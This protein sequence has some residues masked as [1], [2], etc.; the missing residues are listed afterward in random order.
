MKSRVLIIHNE[1]AL[2]GGE[3][4]AVE[5]QRQLFEKNGHPVAYYSR[6]NTETSRYSGVERALF[7]PSTVFS[8]RT[9]RDIRKLVREFKPDVAHV[10]N[11]FPLISPSAYWALRHEGVPIIQTVHNF[12]LMCSNG[13]FFRAGAICELCKNG[14]H[15]NAVRFRCYRDSRLLSGLYATTLSIHRSVRTWRIIDRF[16]ALNSFTAGKLVDSGVARP[17]QVTVLGN[18]ATNAQSS[19]PGA[20]PREPAVVF[21][22]RLSVE[23][24]VDVLLE[25]ARSTPELTVRILGEGP[26]EPE[27]RRQAQGLPNV[28]FLGRIDGRERFEI[29]R[30]A[31]AVVIP[32]ISYENFNM[33]LLEAMS[34]GTPVIA[35][36]LGSL[37]EI[38]SDGV[39][40]LL[41]TVGDSLD[42]A[43]K[44]RIAG[45]QPDLMAEL[46]ANGFGD[47]L[48][49]YRE[50]VH[51]RRL[52][53][54]Q[55]EV[56][57]RNR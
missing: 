26:N 1:Y 37:A 23:K 41:F 56:M 21:L 4:T 7:F 27:L 8:I 40:S 25:A 16:V 36:R 15:R 49:K 29:I 19:G 43:E 11:V 51:Y 24:G 17:E 42:L 18:F 45:S 5:L 3:R 55:S 33:V 54:I 38:L 10:H 13:L 2:A 48:P 22:G 44:L 47:T 53:E 46:G 6:D 50:E 14:Q 30:R 31:R 35:S 12:R 9:Y 34:V 39:D 57:E 32:S 52:V 20:G 28:E